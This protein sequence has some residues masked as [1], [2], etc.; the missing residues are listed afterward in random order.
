MGERTASAPPS[1][2]C[3]Q[4]NQ[5]VAAGVGFSHHPPTDSVTQMT[6]GHV[7]LSAEGL[8]PTWVSHYKLVFP[9]WGHQVGPSP[10]RTEAKGSNDTL[11][12]AQ[13]MIPIQNN[14]DTMAVT[15]TWFGWLL[16]ALA[17]DSVL[18]FSPLHLFMSPANECRKVSLLTWWHPLKFYVNS[19]KERHCVA[20]LHRLLCPV[21][22]AVA[23]WGF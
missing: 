19:L 23:M 9:C 2:S 7:T 16:W 4:A 15:F 10:C 22:E 13:L 1:L 3:E 21:D 5:S 8:L 11:S 18:S 17:F 12:R 14:C 20:C 6:Q